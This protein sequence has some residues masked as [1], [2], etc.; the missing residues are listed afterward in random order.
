MQFTQ[1]HGDDEA[2]IAFDRSAWGVARLMLLLDNG[3]GYFDSF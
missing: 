3:E 1:V 2:S